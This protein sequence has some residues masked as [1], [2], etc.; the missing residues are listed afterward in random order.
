MSLRD[1]SGRNWPVLGPRLTCAVRALPLLSLAA[2]AASAS[3]ACLV[4]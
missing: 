4:F 3:E 2:Q 1:G